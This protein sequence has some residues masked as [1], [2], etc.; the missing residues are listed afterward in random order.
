MFPELHSIEFETQPFD[1]F[2]G[3]GKLPAVGTGWLDWLE[4]EAPWELTTTEFYEQYEFSLLHVSLPPLVQGLAS[5]GTLTA[6]RHQM[7]GHFR[8]PLSRRVDVTA[9]RLVPK[10][11]IRIHNDYIPGGESHRLLLQLNRGWGP[12]AWR[13]LDVLRWA[14]AGNG[15]QDRRAGQRGR[16][17]IR[18]LPSIPS[19][20]QHGSCRRTFH[21]RVLVP[22]GLLT[23]HVR[24]Q[25]PA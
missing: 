5:L 10:Q 15:Q 11:T 18:H 6:L 23:R 24:K 19:R 13:V 1:H 7:S 21:R 8:H 17:G 20:R 16:T 3:R 12:L 9:H 2:V 25:E 14:A 4:T 22:S